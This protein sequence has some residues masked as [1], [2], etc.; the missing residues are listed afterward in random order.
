MAGAEIIAFN[1][2]RNALREAVESSTHWMPSN[3]ARPDSASAR[4]KVDVLLY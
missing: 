1:R 4:F 2:S 3:L